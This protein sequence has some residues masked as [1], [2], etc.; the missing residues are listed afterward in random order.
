MSS[1]ECVIC[2][3]GGDV[4]P[5]GCCCRGDLGYAHAECL[6]QAA[7][8]RSGRSGWW[9]CSV[10]KRDYTGPVQRVLATTF[11]AETVDSPPEVRIEA[12]SNMAAAEE[13]AGEHASAE[14]GFEALLKAVERDYDPIRTR[15]GLQFLRTLGL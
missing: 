4:L 13:A 14:A 2:L 1:P 7:R 10:C 8:A 12:L 6:V 9:Q 15:S 5:C 11:L 3:E